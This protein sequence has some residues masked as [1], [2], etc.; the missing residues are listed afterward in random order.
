MRI[1]R[2]QTA[3]DIDVRF[4]HFPLHPETPAE[5]LTLE[6]LFAGRGI[7]I[8]ASQ[9]RMKGLMDDEGLPYGNRTMTYNSRLAQELASYAITRPGGDQIHDR[10]F[11]AYFVDG[12]NIASIDILIGI[13]TSIGL[14]ETDCRA[15]L[16]SRHYREAVD[17][18][19]SRSQ[20]LGLTGV[21]AFVVGQNGVTG[22]Q[23]YEVLRQ[24]VEQSGASR[25]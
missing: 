20:T 3:W 10:L 7:D 8:A 14:C 22:A 2:L 25:R 4:V 13:A 23:P 24:L 19:W 16:T 15:A 12:L 17:T 6:Q 1:E 18:D 11:R 21:P 5:G 9:A